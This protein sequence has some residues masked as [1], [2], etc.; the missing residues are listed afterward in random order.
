MHT[1]MDGQA[2]RT[3]PEP[4]I[5]RIRGDGTSDESRI[6]MMH[7]ERC[8]QR[9]KRLTGI[10]FGVWR[11]HCRR[12]EPYTH[13]LRIAQEQHINAHKESTRGGS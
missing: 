10:V 1:G 4:R 8:A 2:Q 9:K 7:C 6:G 3:T 13:S 11:Y 12:L 5:H